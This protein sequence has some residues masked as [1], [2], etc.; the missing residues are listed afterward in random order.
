MSAIMPLTTLADEINREHVE[1]RS[2]YGSAVDHALR[3]G[4]L[5]TQAKKQC[6][7]GGWLPWLKDN[8]PQIAERTAQAYMRLHRERDRLP[9][10]AT[11]ADLT[12]RDTMRELAFTTG[13]LSKLANPC[14]AVEIADTQKIPLFRAVTSAL[15]LDRH[16][17]LEQQRAPR[18]PASAQ[19]NDRGDDYD[20]LND[21]ERE[22]QIVEL[23]NGQH[24]I[25]IGANDFGRRITCWEYMGLCREMEKDQELAALR[26]QLKS[27]RERLAKFEAEYRDKRRP[28]AGDVDRCDRALTVAGRELAERRF[29][30]Y[31]SSEFH[32][33]NTASVMRMAVAGLDVEE[34][35][36]GLRAPASLVRTIGLAA[37]DEVLTE[38]QP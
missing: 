8:C 5:L 29:G 37:M 3:V 13:K 22:V 6:P 28:F 33:L 1:A 24:R 25:D 7:H 31:R 38:A 19:G 9:K 10:S 4:E 35:A 34:I 27:A 11:V 26:D 15:R 14:V 16:K 21:P 30:K 2:A 12:F 17:E 36:K 18:A 23:G 20:P 32:F